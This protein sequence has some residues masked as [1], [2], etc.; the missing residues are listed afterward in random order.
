MGNDDKEKVEALPAG[1]VV[2]MLEGL[3]EANDRQWQT[4]CYLVAGWALTIVSFAVWC[5]ISR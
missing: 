4:I 1:V 5:I 2:M 3:R